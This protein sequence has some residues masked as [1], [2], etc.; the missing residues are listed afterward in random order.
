MTAVFKIVLYICLLSFSE[1]FFCN[2]QD[3][4]ESESELF[5]DYETHT[6]L[7]DDNI[8]QCKWSK[9]VNRGADCVLRMCLEL[10]CIV[11]SFYSYH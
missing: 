11:L 7:F 8:M 1:K 9:H 10:I 2:V 6:S 5:E 4:T 3:N